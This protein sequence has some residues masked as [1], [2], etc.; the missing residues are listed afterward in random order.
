MV[1]RNIQRFKVVVGRFDFRPGNCR[2]AQRKENPLQLR[3]RLPQ[4]VRRADAGRDARQ[5]QIF[6]LAQ[7]SSLLS[8]GFHLRLLARHHRFDMR[9]EFV[10]RRSHRALQFRRGRFKPVVGNLG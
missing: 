5:G 4:D 1:L 10:Q 8:G 3:N 9:L 2:V 7:Q 6:A